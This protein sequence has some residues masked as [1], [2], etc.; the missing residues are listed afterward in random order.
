MHP[1]VI[2]NSVAIIAG[3]SVGLLIGKSLTDRIRNTIFKAV[4]L[5]TLGVGIQMLLE[6]D[7][8]V[9][10]LLSLVVGAAFG[11]WWNIEQRM[12][13]LTKLVGQSESTNFT[14]GFV[15]A[16][17]LF[18]VGPMTIVGSIR[19]GLT[20]NGSLIYV[21]S[22]LDMISSI[23]LSSLYG[24]GVMLSAAAVFIVQGS[25]VLFASNLQF[26]TDTTYLND[27]TGVGGAIVVALG[28]SLLNIKELKAAN[29]LPALVLVPFFDLVFSLFGGWN[30]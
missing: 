27:F 23:V 11:E 15:A 1:S 20:N 25:L 10:V 2:V 16:V 19:A 13:L 26:L 22:V 8:F 5:T 4:G 6:T 29:F 14:K 3:S 18:L 21:K 9:V 7:S 28:I 12:S 17:T 24:L 30:V